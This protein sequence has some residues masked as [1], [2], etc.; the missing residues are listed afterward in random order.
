MLLYIFLLGTK[1]LDR[2][3]EQGHTFSTT[4]HVGRFESIYYHELSGLRYSS[5]NIYCDYHTV[6]NV[7][8]YEDP[9]I[10]FEYI[11]THG[12]ICLMGSNIIWVIGDVI[13]STVVLQS[14]SICDQTSWFTMAT[15][16][17]VICCNCTSPVFSWICCMFLS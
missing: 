13:I 3:E 2:A 12:Y 14:A 8:W 6:D 7:I 4:R 17:R 9:I 5:I 16:E 10:C 15:F 1:I 11:R